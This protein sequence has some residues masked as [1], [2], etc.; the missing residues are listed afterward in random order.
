MVEIMNKIARMG[1]EDLSV[2]VLT[3]IL[4]YLSLKT[5]IDLRLVS[6]E[7]PCPTYLAFPGEH[8]DTHG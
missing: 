6:R 2:E 4:Q 5:V 1:M 3:N 8:S 7:Y